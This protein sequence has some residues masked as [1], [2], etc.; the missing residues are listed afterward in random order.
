M[1]IRTLVN[2]AV[3]IVLILGAYAGPTNTTSADD[4]CGWVTIGGDIYRTSYTK[5]DCGPDMSDFGVF[6]KRE[7]GSSFD[8]S[9]VVTDDSVYCASANGWLYRF[10]IETSTM[11]WQTQ[12]DDCVI[13]TPAL[14]NN[15]L[16]VVS[17]YGRVV[18]VNPENGEIIWSKSIQGEVSASPLVYMDKL[19]IGKHSS[20]MYCLSTADGLALWLSKADAMITSS[21]TVCGDGV[22]AGSANGSITKFDVKDG[23]RSWTKTLDSPVS[24]APVCEGET[25]YVALSEGDIASLNGTTGDILWKEHISDSISTKPVLADDKLII[26]SS[27]GTVSCIGKDDG[28]NIW[29]TKLDSDSVVSSPVA[30]G[31]H[32]FIGGNDGLLSCLDIGSGKIVNSLDLVYPI[33]S[34]PAIS[35]KKIFVGTTNGE[36][37]SLGKTPEPGKEPKPAPDPV[38]EPSVVM[39]GRNIQLIWKRYGYRPVETHEGNIFAVYQIMGGE[40]KFGFK[41]VVLEYFDKRNGKN[42]WNYETTIGA[43]FDDKFGHLFVAK[44][45]K[46]YTSIIGD[47]QDTRPENYWYTIVRYDMMTKKRDW[48]TGTR[49]NTAPDCPASLRV[50][51]GKVYVGDCTGQLYCLDA[52]TGFEL[53]KTNTDY[54]QDYQTFLGA[55]TDEYLYWVNTELN[56]LDRVTG[57]K[58]WAFDSLAPDVSGNPIVWA[59]KLIVASRG[60]QLDIINCINRH[61]GERF[62]SYDANGRIGCFRMFDEILIF[63]EYDEG[64]EHPDIV[65]FD[66]NTQKEIWRIDSDKYKTSVG[67]KFKELIDETY[68]ITGTEDETSFVAA[69]DPRTGKELWTFPIAEPAKRM[70]IDEDRYYASSGGKVFYIEGE[71]STYCYGLTPKHDDDVI[72]D[73]DPEPLPEPEPEPEPEPDPIPP[74]G[75][76]PEVKPRTFDPC[77]WS[78][79]RGNRSGSGSISD[80]CAPLE[81]ELETLWVY[82]DGIVTTDPVI[83]YGR[84]YFTT[85]TGDRASQNLLCISLDTKRVIWQREIPGSDNSYLSLTPEAV[86]VGSSDGNFYLYDQDDGRRLFKFGYPYHPSYLAPSVSTNN[87]VLFVSHH[88]SSMLDVNRLHCYDKT[89]DEVLWKFEDVNPKQQPLIHDG[90]VVTLTKDDRIVGINLATGKQLWITKEDTLFGSPI[91]SNGCVFAR[92]NGKRLY[93]FDV[94]T[95]EL[96]WYHRMEKN[97]LLPTDFLACDGKNVYVIAD[98]QMLC[99]DAKNGEIVWRQ[100]KPY[101]INNGLVIS[102]SRIFTTLDGR[103]VVLDSETGNTLYDSQFL[104]SKLV[105]ASGK[106]LTINGRKLVCYKNKTPELIEP[107]PDPEPVDKGE[108]EE[109]KPIVLKY[110]LGSIVYTVDD[111]VNTMNVEPQV[112]YGRTMLPARYVVEP[113][114]GE[115]LWDGTERKVTCIV[116]KKDINP[117]EERPP[118]VSERDNSDKGIISDE[119]GDDEESVVVE[120]WIGK[121]MAKVDGVEV[122]IDENTSV[123]PNIISGRTMVPMRFIAESLGCEVEWIAE[124][125]MIILT[126]SR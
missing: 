16:F 3:V 31:S 63:E 45:G 39:H 29:Q 8:S 73:P 54:T 28:K 100:R 27:D 53:W 108:D 22:V 41:D 35:D 23:I 123:V 26:V 110:T 1:R 15:Q 103:M 44:N 75:E 38:V 57:K 71:S 119:T 64:E 76:N 96:I 25:I 114:G 19:F 121:N 17:E 12:I 79:S 49:I 60:F 58:L 106:I 61:N 33:Y 70:L 113:L 117:H 48:M 97:L 91:A 13:N 84:V 30:T 78:V 120:L 87:K 36:M 32:I 50:L 95:G 111:Q 93:A 68:Y 40:K 59:N 102:E 20:T 83:G 5:T 90:V 14:Y 46:L 51:E 21:A 107:D 65:G 66:L 77:G 118:I 89:I 115:V 122:A 24:V 34:S 62:W 7:V 72:I 6:W 37:F 92:A 101:D 10:E 67:Y 80:Q 4:S 99:I 82:D 55:Y 109:K 94:Y 124:S 116:P 125:K 52:N 42:L 56:C 88:I 105:I 9:P 86:C 18:C 11:L 2:V 85:D 104:A 112:A 69:V 126:Y 47:H 43:D 98:N 81:G 74:P